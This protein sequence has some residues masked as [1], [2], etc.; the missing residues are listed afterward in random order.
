MT[1]PVF[2]SWPIP[3]I[4]GG[5]VYRLACEHGW[6]TMTTREAHRRVAAQG[7]ILREHVR[8]YGCDCILRVAAAPGGEAD[9]IA[10][11]ATGGRAPDARLD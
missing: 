7:D 10:I 3:G 5:R 9:L 1:R 8:T 6:T 11:V 4:P 2:E